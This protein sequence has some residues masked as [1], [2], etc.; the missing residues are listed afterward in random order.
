MVHRKK[1]AFTLIELLIFVAMFSVIITVLMQIY[2]SIVAKQI[3]VQQFSSVD[4]DQM[5]IL[6]RLQYDLSRT[7]SISTPATVGGTSPSLSL[8]IDG[9]QYTYSAS[10]NRLYLTMGATSEYVNSFRSRISNLMF[11]RLGNPNGKNAI[12]VG[13]TVT[14]TLVDQTPEVRSIYTILSTK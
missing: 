4:T 1:Q 7:T 2:S 3:E 10:A 12:G 5:F 14:S 6:N 8:Q 13:F 11:T 9:S